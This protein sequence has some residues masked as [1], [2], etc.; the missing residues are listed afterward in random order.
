[1][2][3]VL[4]V[5]G[6]VVSH[7]FVRW[8]DPL[9]ITANPDIRGVNLHTLRQAFST[10][11]PEL[12]IPFTLISY[13][14]NYVIAG[15]SPWIYHLVNLLLHL[16]NAVLVGRVILWLTGAHR[17][18]LIAASSDRG[19]CMGECTKGC[20]FCILLSIIAPLLSFLPGAGRPQNIL[21]K[22]PSLSCRTS[23]EGIRRHDACSSCAH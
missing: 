12:Y 20:A 23:L 9:L 18:A 16:L 19:G 10:F 17:G 22:R 2:L 8:D 7:D 14:I 5:F 6:S 3:A 15:L 13:Q 11:D 1:M 4:L 21:W